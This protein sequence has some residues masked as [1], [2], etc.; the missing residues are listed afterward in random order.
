VTNRLGL[1]R[2]TD[3]PFAPTPDVEISQD[4][5]SALWQGTGGGCGP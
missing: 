4:D 3:G 2:V 5:L 1:W